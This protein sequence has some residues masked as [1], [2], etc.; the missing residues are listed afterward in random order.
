MDAKFSMASGGKDQLRDAAAPSVR[1]RGWRGPEPFLT[2][3]LKKATVPA[4]PKL[5]IP[6]RG[7]HLDTAPIR[8]GVATSSSPFQSHTQGDEDIAAPNP[9]QKRAVSR[10]APSRVLPPAD[11]RPQQCGLV[12][13]TFE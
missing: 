11:P 3:T 1:I 5:T 2:E 4:T 9:F 7:A 8:N 6:G 13:R 12:Q 10:C